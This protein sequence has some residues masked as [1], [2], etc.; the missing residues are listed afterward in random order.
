MIIKVKKFLLYGIKSEVDSFFERAQDRGFIEFIGPSKKV[1]ALTSQIKDFLSAIKI[2]RGYPHL[3]LPRRKERLSAD[4][5]A[6]EVVALSA[7][8]EKLRRERKNLEKEVEKLSPLGHFSFEDITFI[9]KEGKRFLQFF[10][11]QTIKRGIEIPE[12]LIFVNSELDLD[13][14][15]SVNKERIEV[16]GMNEIIADRPLHEVEKQLSEVND[17][18]KK[19]VYDL[20]GYVTYIKLLQRSIVE[21]LDEYNLQTTKENIA[22]P[23]EKA[24]F[25]VEAWAPTSKLAEFKS[26]VAPFELSFEE[27]AIEKFDRVP[28]YLENKEIPKIGEDLVNI[29]DIPSLEDK[30]PSP[31]VLIF[32]SIFFAMILGDAGYGLIILLIGLFLKYKMKEH[33]ASMRRFTKLVIILGCSSIVWGVATLSFL[34]IKVNPANKI[35]HIAPLYYLAEKKANYHLKMK[36]DVYEEW[37]KKYP[38]IKKAKSGEEFLNLAIKKEDHKVIYEAFREFSKNILLEFSLLIG[39]IHICIGSL[40]NL[41]RNLA[42]IGWI[43]FLVGGYLFCPIMLKSTTFLNFTGIINRQTEATFALPL[44]FSG[45]FIATFLGVIQRKWE[46]FKEILHSVEIFSDVMSYLRLYALDLAGMMLSETFNEMGSSI[47]LFFGIFI[48]LIGHGVNISLAMMGGVIH[49]LRLNFIE[50]YHYCFEGGGKLFNPLRLLR[51]KY[52]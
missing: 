38:A 24:I 41:R 33:S 29:Y 5:A 28:T 30:D 36:D 39:V 9:Q 13:Y 19:K 8:L 20:K 17:L 50:W 47:R 40:I 43:I 26:L 1:H 2:L 10:C 22:H 21:K 12:F 16:A 44:L 51:T 6:K 15:V 37:S 27:I 45:L 48:M 14:F 31:W 52:H 3:E 46:G 18:I 34:G 25:A 49:G 42:G 7:T 11:R 35:T 4:E 32:F 23:L